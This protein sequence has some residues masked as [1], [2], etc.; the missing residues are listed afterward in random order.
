MTLHQLSLERLLEA[1]IT[2]QKIA[3]MFQLLHDT[4]QAALQI[5]WAEEEPAEDELVPTL[6]FVLMPRRTVNEPQAA[7]ATQDG[8]QGEQWIQTE[9]VNTE[10]GESGDLFASGEGE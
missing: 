1:D 8:T 2:S 6:F 9:E 4:N 7:D 3:D 5:H 10:I